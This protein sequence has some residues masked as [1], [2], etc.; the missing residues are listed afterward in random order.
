MGKQRLSFQETPKFNIYSCI[1]CS[2]VH[3]GKHQ[4]TNVWYLALL[5]TE[6]YATPMSHAMLW[7]TWSHYVLFNG[8]SFGSRTSDSSVALPKQHQIGIAVQPSSNDTLQPGIQDYRRPKH[9]ST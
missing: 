4:H 3:V 1:E 8:S 5:P 9:T 2:F 6:E 7:D